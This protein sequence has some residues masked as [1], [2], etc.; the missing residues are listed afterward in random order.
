MISVYDILILI[1]MPMCGSNMILI[2]A[3][4]HEQ[5]APE[6]GLILFQHKVCT[7]V[8]MCKVNA[9]LLQFTYFF[10]CMNNNDKTVMG[11]CNII[12]SIISMVC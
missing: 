3:E 5:W 7:L 1:H 11:L 9:R 2:D 10:I 12:F 6:K 8:V 4:M